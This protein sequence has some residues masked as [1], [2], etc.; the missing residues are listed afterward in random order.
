MT[1][2][3]LRAIRYPKIPK[4]WDQRFMYEAAAK[5]AWSK[6][7]STRVGAVA[8]RE[9]R[10]IATGYNGLPAGILD[11]KERLL[12][13]ELRLA[14]TIH[15]EL[16]LVTYAARHGVCLDGATVYVYPLLPCSNCATSLIQVGIAKVVAP[17]FVMPMRWAESIAR[18]RQAF[19]E[20][21]VG[22]ELLAVEGPL[23]CVAASNPDRDDVEETEDAHLR[24]V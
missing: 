10:I 8:V 3:N 1:S 6:D 15:A 13:R 16:N 22:V 21:G 17:D 14:L 23:C 12:D 9:R 11:S 2:D 5:A 4:D 24:L 18:A 20:A 19:W 7:P